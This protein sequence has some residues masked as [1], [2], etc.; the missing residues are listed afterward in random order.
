M[1]IDWRKLDA[2]REAVKSLMD[3]YDLAKRCQQLHEAASLPVPDP[4]K[5]FLG[6]SDHQGTGTAT[7]R[8]ASVEPPFHQPP[9]E[10]EGDWVS[11]PV[12]EASVSSVALAILRQAGMMRARDLNEAVLAILPEATAGSVAN[13]G[14]RLQ[15]T[16]I[17]RTE[18][19][20]K[21][22]DTEAA[23][24]ITDDRLW[25]PISVFGVHDIA[26]HR[27]E[28]IL[29]ILS[30]YPTG[31]QIVQIVEQLRKCSWVHAPVNKDLLKADMEVLQRQD[32]AR[33]RGNS[34]KW[35]AVSAETS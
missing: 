28:A 2:E 11:I 8:E 24:I 1:V 6:M 3:L 21:L 27:R 22:L 31:L 25:G 4:L 13:M 26:A 12:A 5:R 32:K 35:E 7:K 33:R 23:G 18:D 20:W 34:K 9:P 30:T 16:V 29:H 10:A 14:T 19:G 17:D 15:G